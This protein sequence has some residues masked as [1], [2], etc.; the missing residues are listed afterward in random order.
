VLSDEK[1]KRRRYD[2][3]IKEGVVEYPDSMNYNWDW[4]D[5]K[6]GLKTMHYRDDDEAFWAKGS[7]RNS[8]YEEAKKFYE[9]EKQWSWETDTTL[10]DLKE[11]PVVLLLILAAAA[12]FFVPRQMLDKVMKRTVRA[13]EK[14]KLVENIQRTAKGGGGGEGAGMKSGIGVSKGNRKEVLERQRRAQEE[15]EREEEAGAMEQMELARMDLTALLQAHLGDIILMFAAKSSTD[16][17]AAIDWRS[18]GDER[19]ISNGDILFVCEQI[20]DIDVLNRYADCLVESFPVDDAISEDG[21]GIDVEKKPVVDK[22]DDSLEKRNNLQQILEHVILVLHER[23]EHQQRMAAAHIKN[24]VKSSGEKVLITR[25]WDAATISCLAKGVNK[26]QSHRKRWDLVTDYMN[27]ILSP[28]DPF[29]KP[30]CI[31]Q[32]Q[33]IQNTVQRGQLENHASSK[34]D[35]RTPLPTPALS[36]KSTPSSLVKT[37]GVDRENNL[38]SDDHG[39]ATSQAAGDSAIWSVDQQKQLGWFLVSHCTTA[40]RSCVKTIM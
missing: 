32:A 25:Q 3:L 15:A 24:K 27:H 28:S 20:K 37:S 33:V 17:A 14:K 34:L 9:A 11:N 35:A 7:S 40:I 12:L 31:Q 19:D 30:E 6:I 2:C 1:V 23:H 4:I 18:I 21:A 26:Y 8:A 16:S 39:A 13:G 22:D 36:E 29:T 10:Q 38:S 5:Q